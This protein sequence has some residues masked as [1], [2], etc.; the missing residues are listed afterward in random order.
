METWLIPILVVKSNGMKSLLCCLSLLPLLMLG[1][2]Q[3]VDKKNIALSGYDP[4]SYFTQTTPAKGNA[5]YTASWERAIYHFSSA[6]NKAVFEQNPEQYAP[7]YG[8]WCA[9]A[10]A[11]NKT[12]EINPKA[13]RIEKNKLYLFY[14]TRWVD[15]HQKWGERAE[16]FREKADANWQKR[17]PKE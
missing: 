3:N 6:E 9:Y 14:K 5:H 13:F 11:K 4:V 12:V 2:T 10:M 7:Q 17:T 8:G 15:T 16:E 1:Q